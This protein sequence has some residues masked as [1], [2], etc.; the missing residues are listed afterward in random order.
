MLRC[1]DPQLPA[2]APRHP[3]TRELP[4]RTNTVLQCSILRADLN[5]IRRRPPPIRR[6]RPQ[7][8]FSTL[9]IAD[10]QTWAIPTLMG[11]RGARY[12]AKE[13]LI[14]IHPV[15]QYSIP[16]ARLKSCHRRSRS[17]ISRRRR[18]RRSARRG[19]AGPRL[20]SG[21]GAGATD[22][23]EILSVAIL[24]SSAVSQGRAQFPGRFL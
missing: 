3:I 1:R 14:S 15:L 8:P 18:T 19:W 5:P 6:G 20:R 12:Q 13:L 23:R 4:A 22:A 9:R 24:Q 17:P 2:G 11:P 16:R 10:P 21:G 7:P